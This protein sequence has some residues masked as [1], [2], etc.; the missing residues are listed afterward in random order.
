MK[1]LCLILLVII[2]LCCCLPADAIK[3]EST[4]TPSP[5]NVISASPAP[6]RID[7]YGRVIADNT[8]LYI[9]PNKNAPVR[10]SLSSDSIVKMIEY[11]CDDNGVWWTHIDFDNGM[12]GYV[13][14]VALRE[15]TRNEVTG[16]LKEVESML[17]SNSATGSTVPP[18]MTPT[19]SPAPTQAPTPTPSPTPTQAPTPT[20]SPTPTQTPTPTSAAVVEDRIRGTWGTCPWSIDSDGVLTVNAGKGESFTS[21]PWGDYLEQIE[22]AY[23][24]DGVVFPETCSR[25]FVNYKGDT[26]EYHNNTTLRSVY[27][28]DVDTSNVRDMNGMFFACENLNELDL[29]QFNTGKVTR[30]YGMFGNCSNLSKLNISSFDT[31]KVTDMNTMFGNCTS[32]QELDVSHFDTSNVTSMAFMFFGCANLSKLDLSHFDTGKV[33]DMPL[34]FANCSSLSELD[35]HGFD[36]SAVTDLSGMF[37]RCSSLQELDVSSFRTSNVVDMRFMFSECSKLEKLDLSHFD[38]SNVELMSMMLAR[39]TSLKELDVTFFDTG[40]VTDMAGVFLEDTELVLSVIEGSPLAE[41][42]EPFVKKIIYVQKQNIQSGG[43]ESLL[44]SSP[45]LESENIFNKKDETATELQM[46]KDDASQSR[47]EIITDDYVY[48]V[49]D[50]ENRYLIIT[51]YKGKGGDIVIPETFQGM[52]VK[53]IGLEAFCACRELKS[54]VIPEGIQIIGTRAFAKC[55]KLHSVDLPESLEEIAQEAFMACTTLERIELP[56]NLKHIGKS[57]FQWCSDLERMDIPEGITVIEENT[58]DKCKSLGQINM[59]SSLLE[60]K[61]SAFFGCEGLEY[62]SLPGGVT[63]IEGNPF[64]GCELLKKIEIGSHNQYFTIMNGALVEKAGGRLIAFPCR[65]SEKITYA[66]PEEIKIIE[67]QAFSDCMFTTIT[68]PEGVSRIGMYAFSSCRWLETVHVPESVQE[69]GEE[70]FFN[71]AD[72]II[73]GKKGSF[74]EQYCSLNGLTFETVQQ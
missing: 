51:K 40:K 23:F 65:Q 48:Y 10:Y 13:Q 54:I 70:A 62:I 45:V 36:T 41:E 16:Y 31:S 73:R 67:E 49:V 52:P 50:T 12:Q 17:V 6:V 19:P 37:L 14:S 55:P 35:I 74:I 53:A 61:K 34:M 1:R 57:A 47:S 15:L 60:I 63:K 32:L 27:F 7:G 20:P 42:A 69:I 46:P 21:S 71:D 30:M 56:T 72:V 39:C 22:R 25:L 11:V 64:I 38:T 24:E 44:P 68:I 29:G 26:N 9:K 3:R 4:S 66:I 58:F 59:P 8:L 2:M 43:M 5:E 18:E 33:T 28:A